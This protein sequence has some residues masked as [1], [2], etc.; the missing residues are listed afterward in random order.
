ML[1]SGIMAFGFAVKVSADARLDSMSAD[2]RQVEDLDIIWMYPNKVLEYKDTVDFRM[3]G[4][5]NNGTSNTWGDGMAEWGGILK[6]TVDSGVLGLYLNRPMNIAQLYSGFEPYWI[7]VAGTNVSGLY[8]MAWSNPWMLA[9]NAGTAPTPAPKNKFDLFWAKNVSAGDLGIQVNYADNDH[10]AD[11]NDSTQLIG[12]NV[13]LGTSMGPFNQANFHLNG[14]VGGYD[15]E[16]GLTSRTGNGIWEWK[17]GTLLQS[18]L[19]SDDVLKLG[20]DLQADQFG[21][22][23]YNKPAGKG[24]ESAAENQAVTAVVVNLGMNHKVT[25]GKGLVS[26]GLMFGWLG[27]AL[28]TDT[29]GNAN[30]QRNDWRVLGNIC[31]ETPIAGWLTWR[32]GIM[33]PIVAWEY[34]NNGGTHTAGQAD[35]AI[36]NESVFSTGFGFNVQNWTLDTQLSVTSLEYLISEPNLGGVFYGT[37]TPDGSGTP[38]VEMVQADLRYK[39]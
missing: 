22:A 23:S 9:R 27:Y 37:N 10:V 5:A 2:V 15:N 39:F 36:G 33:K 18:D 3:N 20:L 4:I 28:T 16:A 11:L 32:A 19:S 13:G 29:G 21:Y 30:Y 24:V 17:L 12:V 34:I 6:D 35:S 26:A 25:G 7:P 8:G 1:L 38:I 31:A 14:Q